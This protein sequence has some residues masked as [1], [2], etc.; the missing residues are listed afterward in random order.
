MVIEEAKTKA[1][2]VAERSKDN[3]KGAPRKGRNARGNT[4]GARGGPR[5][6]RRWGPR[7]DKFT[8]PQLEAGDL[9]HMVD[10]GVNLTNPKFHQNTDYV[11]ARALSSGEG[12]LPPCQA[13]F[14]LLCD[15]RCH[16]FHYCLLK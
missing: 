6:G 8:F 13:V 5:G 4:R 3:K 14:V 1:D 7:K 9:F 15:V 2:H 16:Y 11:I 10:C 12:L